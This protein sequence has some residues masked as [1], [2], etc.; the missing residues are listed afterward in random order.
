MCN[1]SQDL[2]PFLVLVIILAKKSYTATATL[3]FTRARC[4][5]NNDHPLLKHICMQELMYGL[6]VLSKAFCT[7]PYAASSEL[8]A[9]MSVSSCLSLIKPGREWQ[10]CRA[11]LMQC[12]KVAA[13]IRAI[14]DAARTVVRCTPGILS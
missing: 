4:H 11:M 9:N 1:R 2:G 8:S 13:V 14:S 10:E 6:I 3:K 5:V 12:M 7:R